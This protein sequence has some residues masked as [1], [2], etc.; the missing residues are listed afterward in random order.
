[1]QK[2]GTME[3]WFTK[4][5]YGIMEQNFGKGYDTIQ[6]TR[7][8]RLTKEKIHGRLPKTMKLWFNMEKKLWY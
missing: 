3:L 4:E 6:K 5:K 2:Y 1:M 7:E 8:L